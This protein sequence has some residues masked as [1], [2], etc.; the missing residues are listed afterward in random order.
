MFSFINNIFKKEVSNAE[1]IR[2]GRRDLMDLLVKTTGSFMGTIERLAK[3][4]GYRGE[5]SQQLNGF[6]YFLVHVG[7]TTA[8]K[9]LNPKIS[10]LDDYKMDIFK[11]HAA[12]PEDISF[13]EDYY[14]KSRLFYELVLEQHKESPEKYEKL[15]ATF[16]DTATNS[17]PIND[18]NLKQELI[19]S[20]SELIIN[21]HKEFVSL[22]KLII[23]R[24]DSYPS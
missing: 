4:K 6:S 24:L 5:L 7:I 3:V 17:E 20:I 21:Q 11:S 16:L 1:F 2:L 22:L 23:T 15:C 18:T 13:V 12:N 9:E 10:C 8:E 14:E 19:R